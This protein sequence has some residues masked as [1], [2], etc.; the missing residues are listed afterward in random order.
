MSSPAVTSMQALAHLYVGAPPPAR[1]ADEPQG[2][3]V[4]G[5]GLDGARP[6]PWKHQQQETFQAQLLVVC[7]PCPASLYGAL[8]PCLHSL[9]R[10]IWGNV[11]CKPTFL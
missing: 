3:W 7:W 1:P 2:H 10:G 8:V 9:T 4:C 6:V 5:C 11:N